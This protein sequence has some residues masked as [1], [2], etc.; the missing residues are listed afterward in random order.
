MFKF[1]RKRWLT[2]KVYMYMALARY[3]NDMLKEYT[4]KFRKH[5]AVLE[6]ALDELSE[7]TVEE[8]LA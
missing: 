1:I 5:N 7:I 3:D 8:S 4:D 2:G 6:K